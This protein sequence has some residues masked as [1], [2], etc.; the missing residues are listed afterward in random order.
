MAYAERKTEVEYI[1]LLLFWCCVPV[2][3]CEPRHHHH[4]VHDTHCS[5]AAERKKETVIKAVPLE[6][7]P[8]RFTFRFVLF[9]F[10]VSFHKTIIKPK[11]RRSSGALHTLSFT[12]PDEPNESAEKREDERKKKRKEERMPHII[13]VLKSGRTRRKQDLANSYLNSS[14]T[15]QAM[16]RHL[17]CHHTLALSVSTSL[18]FHSTTSRNDAHRLTQAVL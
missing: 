9:S 4:P 6:G 13:V 16:S 18:P 11:K 7:L 12:L 15:Q 14:N 3:L 10:Y 1:R 5:T 8:P 2:S 17:R